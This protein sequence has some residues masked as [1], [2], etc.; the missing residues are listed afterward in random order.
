MKNFVKYADNKKR[1]S[2]I[3]KRL[4]QG[5]TLSSIA[6]ELEISLSAL[7]HYCTRH[8]I[9]HNRDLRIDYNDV[10][11]KKL[12]RK[13]IPL[14]T[15]SE[16]LG[17]PYPCL[18]AHCKKMK[19][20]FIAKGILGRCHDYSKVPA[21]VKKGMTRPDISKKLNIPYHT[22]YDYCKYHRIDVKKESRRKIGANV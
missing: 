7:S 14:A 4:R 3:K 6:E 18:Y 1:T 21:M 22:L 5:W 16:K 8:K 20:N 10:K 2:L 9:E 19:F 15:I 13:K 11:I 12:I 17:I